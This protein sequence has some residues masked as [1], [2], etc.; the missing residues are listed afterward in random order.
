LKIV[1]PSFPFQIHPFRK[2]GQGLS[3]IPVIADESVD[4]DFGTGAVKVTPAHDQVS[5]VIN[6]LV[7]RD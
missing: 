2:S 6:L 5:L 1:A 7:I 4:P 3:L